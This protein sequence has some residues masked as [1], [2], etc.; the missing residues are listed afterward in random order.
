[1]MFLS[2]EHMAHLLTIDLFCLQMK[3]GCTLTLGSYL[4]PGWMSVPNLRTFI[5]SIPKKQH[6][7]VTYHRS[8]WWYFLFTLSCMSD[9]DFIQ[10]ICPGVVILTDLAPKHTILWEK[11]FL[12]CITLFKTGNTNK[13]W[14]VIYLKHGSRS[15]MV[16]SYLFLLL[17]IQLLYYF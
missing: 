13:S 4:H 3:V 5:Q 15:V 2:A 10:A 6:S 9:V 12:R 17:R 11:A 16:W 14:S 7:S 8:T 1:M